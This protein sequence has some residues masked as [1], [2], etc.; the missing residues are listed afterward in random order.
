MITKVNMRVFQPIN[1]TIF[2]MESERTLST[3][4]RPITMQIYCHLFDAMNQHF[5]R[6][7]LSYKT[8]PQPYRQNCPLDYIDTKL[9]ISTL[10]FFIYPPN[11]QSNRQVN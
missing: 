6:L 5:G 7:Q 1:Q 3:Y 9:Y 2:S 8:K 11:S 10:R 4:Y